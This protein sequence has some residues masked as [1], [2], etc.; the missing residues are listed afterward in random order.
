MKKYTA[1]FVILLLVF[2]VYGQ[3]VDFDKYFINKTMR[4]DFFHTGTKA[5]EIVSFDKIKMEP[6][7]AGSKKKLIDDTNFGKYIFKIFD[8]RTNRLIYSRGFCSIFGEWQTT[9]EAEKNLTRSFHESLIFPYPKNKVKIELYVRD[10]E[11]FFKPIYYRVIDP[12]Y[13]NIKKELRYTE[14]RV[15][16]LKISGD[17]SNKVDILILAEGYTK[18]QIPKFRKDAQKNVEALFTYEPFKSNKDKFNIRLLEIISGESGIDNPN[19]NIYKNSFLDCS[20]NSFGSDR[21]MLT[22]ANNRIRD[23]ASNAPYDYLCIIVNTDKYGGGGIFR[24]Y[25][26]SAADNKWNEYLFVH[27]FGHNFAGLGD[28]Y[29][30]SD[31]AY[32]EFYPPDVEPWEPNLTA[33]LDKDN[34]KWNYL[35]PEGTP[36]PTPVEEKYKNVVGVYEGGGYSAKGI[37]RP[38]IDCIMKNKD[39]IPFCPVCQSGIQKI[40]DLYTE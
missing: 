11:N 27:E 13:P 40:I 24:L 12:N 28:E 2:S 20:F 6:Y 26:T 32:S 10:K 16:E 31:V 1:I 35:I 21:Y 36:I 15:N 19:K 23:V 9:A 25:S 17:P 4:F 7:W 37:Y 3:V 5:N 29:Y 22:Y 30:T 14:F 34:V 8:T 39:M 18:D 33:L 38:Y